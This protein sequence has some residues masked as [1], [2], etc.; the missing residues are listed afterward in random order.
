MK[1]HIMPWTRGVSTL[2]HAP[3]SGVPDMHACLQVFCTD[4]HLVIVMEYA[5]GGA[6]FDLVRESGHF[7]EDQVRSC[8]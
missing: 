4:Q 3:T 5:A 1:T 7:L 6:L 2:G 8:R